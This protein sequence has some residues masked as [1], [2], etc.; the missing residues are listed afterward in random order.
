MLRA[1]Q[2]ERRHDGHLVCRVKATYGAELPKEMPRI[3]PARGT[4]PTLAGVGI[5]TGEQGRALS[6][7]GAFHRKFPDLYG[8]SGPTLEKLGRPLVGIKIGAGGRARGDW[9]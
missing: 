2:L 9:H 4:A 8:G 5:A 7:G 6:I 3:P 1:F